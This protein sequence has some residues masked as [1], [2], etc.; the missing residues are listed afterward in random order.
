M[1]LPIK[2]MEKLTPEDFAVYPVWELALDL[3]QVD[4]TLVRPGRSIAQSLESAGEG[5]RAPTSSLRR[6]G[7]IFGSKF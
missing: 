5:A 7:Q 6:P 2:N 1:T 4:E 3:E